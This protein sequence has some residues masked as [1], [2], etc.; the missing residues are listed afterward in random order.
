[1]LNRGD[2]AIVSSRCLLNGW[3]CDIV[4]EVN[5]GLIIRDS[6]T[7]FLHRGRKP[8]DDQNHVGRKLTDAECLLR[9]S[10]FLTSV[11]AIAIQQFFGEGSSDAV[12][13]RRCRGAWG[14][15]TRDFHLMGSPWRVARGGMATF[16]ASQSGLGLAVED[17]E[18][19]G[20]FLVEEGGPGLHALLVFNPCRFRGASGYT[21]VDF[22][23]D[24]GVEAID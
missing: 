18:D 22:A 21:H 15:G 16:V 7:D 6:R 12:L 11:T 8:L 1:M 2:H 17:I 5:V 3:P 20:V 14:R 19:L 24:V 13:E 9:G 23:A 10:R 4:T